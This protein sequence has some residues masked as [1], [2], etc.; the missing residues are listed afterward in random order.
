MLRTFLHLAS[1]I[2]VIKFPGT[3]TRMNTMQVA[4][5]NVNSPLGYP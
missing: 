1:A 4:E 3:P 5:A 2:M